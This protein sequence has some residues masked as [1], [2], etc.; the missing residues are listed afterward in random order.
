[1]TAEDT[2]EMLRCFRKLEVI[3]QDG[4]IRIA[5]TKDDFQAYWRRMNE[6][7]SSLFSGLHF[8]H[9]K[10]AVRSDY[11]SEKRSPSGRFR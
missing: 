9:W 10:A 3:Q 11:L 5:I 4:D 8:S 1:M 6:R 7:T 2:K